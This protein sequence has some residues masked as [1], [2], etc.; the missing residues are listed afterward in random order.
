MVGAEFE[1]YK[2]DRTLWSIVLFLRY[3][4]D[5]SKYDAAREAVIATIDEEEKPVVKELWETWKDMKKS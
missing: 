4:M 1:L 2:R 5:N 3:T